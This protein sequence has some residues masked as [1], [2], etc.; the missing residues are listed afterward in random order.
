MGYAF[1]FDHGKLQRA[2]VHGFIA[3]SYWSPNIR[4][5]VL[6]KAL[7]RSV[8]LGV[9]DDESDSQVG[10]ARVVTDYASFAWICDVFVDEDHRGRGIG[11]RMMQE[12]LAHPDL[13]T[14]RRWT[15]GTRDAH[16]FYSQFG[17][18]RAN[19]ESL[20]EYKPPVA[21]WQE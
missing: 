3:S 6:N 11:K 21:N 8:V 19:A 20:M 12:L 10:V 16:A 2:V 4:Y 13:Q 1:S 18:V 7:N 15:L 9:Y 5:D 17:F 14:I